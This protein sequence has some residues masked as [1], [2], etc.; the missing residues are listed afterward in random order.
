MRGTGAR[1]D[2]RTG[3]SGGCTSR[4]DL[5]SRLSTSGPRCRRS[6]A[7]LTRV[8]ASPLPPAR[9]HDRTTGDHPSPDVVRMQ[10]DQILE[11]PLF[12]RSSR[13]TAFLRYVVD[14]TLAGCGDG[15]KEQ[16]LAHALY[17]RD[18]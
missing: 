14:E 11:S 8:S 1:Q 5:T 3:W 17:G 15:I 7:I 6:A 2:P 4:D 18:V 16:V 9:Q 12:A 13:L 10:L